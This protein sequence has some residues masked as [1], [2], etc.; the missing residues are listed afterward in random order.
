MELVARKN[1][2]HDHVRSVDSATSL[3]DKHDSER[4]HPPIL[5]PC[6]YHTFGRKQECYSYDEAFPYE[7]HNIFDAHFNVYFYLELA[8]DVNITIFIR[9]STTTLYSSLEIPCKGDV[10]GGMRGS[11]MQCMA[12]GLSGK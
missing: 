1:R 11:D 3:V 2:H 10:Y 9:L 8:T 4:T 5:A 6:S 12:A 7:N